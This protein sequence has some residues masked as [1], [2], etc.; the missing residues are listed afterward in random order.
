[1]TPSERPR[2]LNLQQRSAL[3]GEAA[4]HRAAE[5]V[6]GRADA[7]ERVRTRAHTLYD[8]VKQLAAALRDDL[9]AAP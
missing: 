7:L 5:L 8:E 4:E 6:A 1:M 3:A 9:L 2:R